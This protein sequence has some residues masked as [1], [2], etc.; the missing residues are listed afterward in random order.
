[1][2][3]DGGGYVD[4][5]EKIVQ[6]A[7]EL[8][9]EM[10]YHEPI[11]FVKG[12]KRKIFMNFKEF[13]DT[14]D[15]RARNMLNAGASLAYKDNVGELE[16]LVFIDEAWMGMNMNIQPSKDPKRIEVLL[17]NTLDP[18]TQEEGLIMFE[19]IRD[20]KG[21][22]VDLKQNSMPE[23]GSVKGMLLPAFQKGYQIISPVTN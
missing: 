6:L 14:S 5:V 15:A 12:S 11:L 13:G 7:K 19:M 16:A 3:L 20:P 10:G 17:I 1:M 9:L 23:G 22:L 8:V 4:D 2:T 21:K 18:K